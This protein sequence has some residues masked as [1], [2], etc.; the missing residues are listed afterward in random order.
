MTPRRRFAIQTD[1][2]HFD[3]LARMA[4]GALHTVS[5]V[6]EELEARMRERVERWLV[7]MDMVPREEFEA[8]KA[9]AQT[10]RIEQE[11][12]AVRVEALEQQLAAQTPK[13]TAAA[14]PRTAKPKTTGSGTTRQTAAGGAKGRSKPA[15]KPRSASRTAP[16]AKPAD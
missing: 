13:K 5:G 2:R 7:D 8:I 16:K 9:V 10:A 3:D 14:K 12:L 11:K 6:R 15:A 4:N 1:N